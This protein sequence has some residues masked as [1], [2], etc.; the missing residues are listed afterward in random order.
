MVFYLKKKN[1]HFSIFR[2]TDFDIHQPLLPYSLDL[3]NKDLLES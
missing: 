3:A 2:N 1:I